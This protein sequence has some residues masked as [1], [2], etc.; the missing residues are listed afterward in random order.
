M[1]KKKEGE[2]SY[3]CNSDQSI[4]EETK[5]KLEKEMESLRQNNAELSRAL[6]DARIQI[7][8]YR[9]REIVLQN[10]L[11]ELREKSYNQMRTMIQ[12]IE[13]NAKDILTNFVTVSDN[14]STILHVCNLF[15]AQIGIM[16]KSNRDE[17][18]QVRTTHAIVKPQIVNGHVLQNPTITLTRAEVPQ[19]RTSRS[20]R[21]D[22]QNESETNSFPS[23]DQESAAAVIEHNIQVENIV[24]NNIDLQS[25]S[26]SSA[27]L[28]QRLST[29]VE[30]DENN[31]DESSATNRSL[32]SK[33]II[34]GIFH[35]VKIYLNQLPME[36][37]NSNLNQC[38][39]NSTNETDKNLSEIMRSLK[40]EAAN[41]RMTVSLSAALTNGMSSASI[42]DS[43]IN[44]SQKTENESGALEFINVKRRKNYQSPLV[45]PES[46]FCSLTPTSSSTPLHTTRDNINSN[47]NDVG[48][49][50]RRKFTTQKNIM[51]DSGKENGSGINLNNK[52]KNKR[53]RKRILSPEN[54]SEEDRSLRLSQRLLNKSKKSEGDEKQ[55]NSSDISSRRPKRAARPCNLK[56]PR[57]NKKMRR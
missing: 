43:T 44:N 11:L 5:E 40:E 29:L 14:L 50:K 22:T 56:E 49:T 55:N 12:T 24:T 34:S 13:R 28:Q 19:Q 38:S 39:S 54:D 52:Q 37:I 4:N 8:D 16:D 41:S 36:M 47:T 31:L 33:S 6:A 20:P 7:G 9:Q 26:R 10:E 57:I 23:L 21:N 18:Q 1:H 27:T 25:S 46:S 48:V 32:R 17:Q 42:N 2:N 15:N 45:S 51:N 53:Q 30:E 35:D 3:S